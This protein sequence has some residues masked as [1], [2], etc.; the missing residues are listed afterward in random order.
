M[1]DLNQVYSAAVKASKEWVPS[2]ADIDNAAI[3]IA[4]LYGRDWNDCCEYE[5]ETFRDEARRKFGAL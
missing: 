2:T 1:T 4:A 3:E 5:R